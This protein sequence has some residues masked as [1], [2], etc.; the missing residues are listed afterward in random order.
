MQDK[1]ISIRVIRSG[2]RSLAMEISPGAEVIVRAPYYATGAD[3]QNFVN[4]NRKWLDEHLARAM[5]ERRRIDESPYGRITRE[6]IQ[7]YADLAL[8]T[9]PPRVSRYAQQMGVTY[10]RIT[11]RCQRTRWGSCSTKKNLNFN[12]LLMLTPP[13]IQ[14]YV[15]VHELAHLREMNHSSRFWAEVETVM[16]DYKERRAWLKNHGHEIIGAVEVWQ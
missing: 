8:K 3:I 4:K 9:I 13:E 6:Q 5:E 1:E 10:H 7:Q 15:I 12:C 11:I 2:R 16:P 14:D